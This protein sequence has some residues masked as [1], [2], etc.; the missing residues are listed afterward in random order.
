MIIIIKKYGQLG[1]RL[2]PFAQFIA[3]AHKHNYRVLNIAFEDY[4]SLFLNTEKSLLCSYPPILSS[5]FF[6]QTMRTVIFKLVEMMV[7]FCIRIK[8]LKS[9]FHEVLLDNS[10]AYFYPDEKFIKSAKS[11][12]VFICN[13][14]YFRDEVTL[15]NNL[16]VAIDFLKIKDEYANN[17]LE[18]TR[19]IRDKYE[20][21]IGIHIRGGDFRTW[22][23]GMYF[24]DIH[25]FKEAIKQAN[26]IFGNKKIG[27]LICSNEIWSNQDFEDSNIYFAHGNLVEDLLLLSKADYLIGGYSSYLYWASLYGNVP[28]FSFLKKDIF[29]NPLQ[30]DDFKDVREFG[31]IP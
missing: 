7:D 9:W 22:A 12:F 25:Y 14:F 27:F 8:F 5:S 21:I 19:E 10:S 11:K 24:Y 3:H 30:I 26:T 18:I 31:S 17:V 2:F 16:E 20:I 29:E 4:S 1:N 15:H 13:P 28:I 6:N 23:D